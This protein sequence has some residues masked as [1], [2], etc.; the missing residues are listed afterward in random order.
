MGTLWIPSLS[1]SIWSFQAGYASANIATIECLHVDGERYGAPTSS[2]GTVYAI[3]QLDATSFRVK[4]RDRAIRGGH[5]HPSLSAWYLRPFS[6]RNLV[7]LDA[8]D[9]VSL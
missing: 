7:M 5:S 3:I 1:F 2:L 9:V 6:R 4:R 8:S